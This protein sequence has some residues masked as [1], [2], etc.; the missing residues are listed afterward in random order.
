MVEPSRWHRGH[1]DL[2][3]NRGPSYAPGDF[4]ALVAVRGLAWIV[5]HGSKPSIPPALHEGL[6]KS[7]PVEWGG[8]GMSRRSQTCRR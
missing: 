3:V 7:C 6:S 8:G 4:Y 1:L 5:T 2:G